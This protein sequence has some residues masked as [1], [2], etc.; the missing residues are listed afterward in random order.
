MYSYSSFL[1][2]FPH[3]SNSPDR[4]RQGRVAH[5]VEDIHERHLR[6]D[7]MEEVRAHVRDRAHEE[8]ARASALDDESVLRRDLLRDEELRGRDEVRERVLLL[9]H[10]SVVVPPL[11][12]LASTADVR[13]GDDGAAVE[14]RET[15]RGERDG[16]RM[17]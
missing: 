1:A 16:I 7:G 2:G 9:E 11:S 6:D 17:P 8:A 10:P 5:R 14:E 12:H 15:V 3:S 4:E 13:D